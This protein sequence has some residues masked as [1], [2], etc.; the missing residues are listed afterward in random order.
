M[1]TRSTEN[2]GDGAARQ[3]RPP[4]L[5]AL[6]IAT[7]LAFV[8]YAALLPVV[9]M[10]AADGGAG[11]VVVGSVTGA[12]MTATVLTQLS[13]PW[14]FRHLSLRTMVVAGSAL[15]GAPTPLYALSA[16]TSAILAI[17]VVRG[18]GFAFVVIAG[19]I[20]AAEIAGP[21]K[22]SSYSAYYGAAAALP[23]V[24]ALAGGVW[25]A[26]VFGYTAVFAVSGA[27]SLCGAVV[28]CWLP[29][30]LHGRFAVPS[31]GDVRPIAIPII[32][33]LMIAGAFG[34]A[35]TFLPLAG[36]PAA[37][38]AFALL[39]ASA[40]LVAGRLLAGFVG[41]RRGAGR[42]LVPSALI[43]AL[44]CLLI[45]V[46]LD[47]P[48]WLLVLGAGLLGLGFGSSQNDS[49]VLTMQR[50]GTGRSGTASIIW[51]IAYDGGLGLGAVG[52]GWFVGTL[53]YA[54]AFI[55]MC[56][57]I[58]AVALLCARFVSAQRRRP[59]AEGDT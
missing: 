31:S 40:A 53:G 5:A 6:L 4:T 37:T 17:T 43:G 41:D 42:L 49:F 16:E 39:A 32:V 52:F 28:A 20:V 1:T 22:L 47:G 12:M 44:G 54:G 10:W 38:V 21:G 30:R 11:S 7:F 33:F 48:T 50:L 15:L 18:V 9:P 58:V 23:N 56:S 55:A 8:N 3:S 14:L 27:A 34:A 59:P 25:A 51:N 26:D 45:S 13:M 57:A 19:A 36:P 2:A 35:T 24:G 29:G 46:S